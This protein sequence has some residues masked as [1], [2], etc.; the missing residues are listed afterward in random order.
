[1]SNLDNL[2]DLFNSLS[3]EEKE[4]LDKNNVIDEIINKI[5]NIDINSE[6]K[7]EELNN[8]CLNLINIIKKIKQKPKCYENNLFI[9]YFII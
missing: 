6:E 2:I 7:R 5:E 8:Y 9:P 3:L 1:M 4:D